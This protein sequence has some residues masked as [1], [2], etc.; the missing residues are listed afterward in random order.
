MDEGILNKCLMH[1]VMTLLYT[2]SPSKWDLD[3][4]MI[5]TRSLDAVVTECPLNW[6][7]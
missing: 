4:R 3:E 6:L 5:A 7:P 1:M 2:L